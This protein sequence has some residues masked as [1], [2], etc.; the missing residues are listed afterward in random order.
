M[1]LLRIATSG[2]GVAIAN[3]VGHTQANLHPPSYTPSAAAT[4]DSLT[5]SHHFA[6]PGP[7][8]WHQVTS[9]LATA[10]RTWACCTAR[11]TPGWTPSGATATRRTAS[12]GF[13]VYFDR[14]TPRG[15]CPWLLLRPGP[16]AG[17]SVLA[18]GGPVRGAHRGPDAL[19]SVQAG[20]PH[21]APPRPKRCPPCTSVVEDTTV[22]TPPLPACCGCWCP[23]ARPDALP[24]QRSGDG[25]LYGPHPSHQGIR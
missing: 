7:R 12:G 3:S 9:P 23:Q 25:I 16:S 17:A 20:T 18:G 21:Q 6:R 19:A 11:S 8:N 14:G 2:L 5:P 4:T 15:S 24:V 13:R 10:S 22:L 1:R